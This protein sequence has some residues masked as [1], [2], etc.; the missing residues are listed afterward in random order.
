MQ[1]ENIILEKSDGI[2][3]V[4]IN[5]PEARNAL[6]LKTRGELL[7]ALEDVG[8]DNEVRVVILTGA[9]D[10]A[11]VAGADLNL[12]DKMNSVEIFE[13]CHTLGGQRLMKTVED[14]DKPVIAAINGFAVGGGCELAMSCDIRIASENAKFG[15]GEINVGIIPG[16]G[17]TQRL[18]RLVGMGIAKELV[19]TGDLID[20]GE[21]E[22]IGLV[23]RV[24][25]QDKLQDTVMELAKK[26][27][28]KSPLILKYAKM[29]MNRGMKTDLDSGLAYE[30]QMISLCFATEDKKEGIKAFLEKRK[31]EFKGR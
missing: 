7:A 2:A 11:F 30:A 27:A 28:S 22:R 21:A 18:P 14:M 31:P 1:F 19:Y 23:N 25:P 3:K 15:Q 12:F 17:G 16:G 20:S 26:I 8:S 5:R 4:T 6:D 29:A 13:F 24:V 10:K 9:G